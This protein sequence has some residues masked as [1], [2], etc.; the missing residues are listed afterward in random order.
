[1]EMFIP[2]ESQ[3]DNTESWLALSLGVCLCR[4]T[5]WTSYIYYVWVGSAIPRPSCSVVIFLI[6]PFIIRS[7]KFLNRNWLKRAVFI[8]NTTL[9][10]PLQIWQV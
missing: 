4:G 8:S 7:E 5:S 3:V 9:E 10:I 6:Y 1:M 2:V